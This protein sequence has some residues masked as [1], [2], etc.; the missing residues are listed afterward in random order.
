MGKSPNEIGNCPFAHLPLVEP[1]IGNESIRVEMCMNEII[2]SVWYKSKNDSC[3]LN[4]YLFLMS[5]DYNISHSLHFFVLFLL[6]SLYIFCYL[7]FWVRADSYIVTRRR[8]EIYISNNCMLRPLLFFQFS[9]FSLDYYSFSFEAKYVSAE[10]YWEWLHF[11]FPKRDRSI[12][13]SIDLIYSTSRYI[14]ISIPEEYYL[15]K[16]TKRVGNRE[17][18]CFVSFQINKVPVISIFNLTFSFDL[19]DCREAKV[20]G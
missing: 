3:K 8:N 14:Y 10:K 7:L 5:Y 4:I 9:S 13:F 11:F 18:H 19:F 17:L 12:C 16:D 2:H 6:P 15:I 1:L 20:W